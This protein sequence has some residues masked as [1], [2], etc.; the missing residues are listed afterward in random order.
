MDLDFKQLKL[1]NYLTPRQQL[2]QNLMNE[3]ENFPD[4]YINKD[5]HDEHEYAEFDLT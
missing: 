1:S 5:E 2:I 3:I 4:F